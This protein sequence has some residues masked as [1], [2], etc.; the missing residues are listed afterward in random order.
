VLKKI[1]RMV[2]TG[3]KLAEFYEENNEFENAYQE[4]SKINNYRKAG[5]M[6]ERMEKW[7][8]AANLYI[9]H[10][11]IDRARKSIDQCFRTGDSW[12]TFEPDNGKTVSIETWLKQK[13]QVQRFVRYIKFVETLNNKGI[14]LVVILANKLRQALEFKSAADL[15]RTG[16]HLVN[17]NKETRLIINEVWLKYATECLANAKLYSDAAECMKELTITEVNIG[18]AIAMSGQN[19][20]RDYTPNLKTARELN[21]LPQLIQTLGDFDPF[22]LSYDLLKIQEPELSMELFF[23]FYGRILDKQVSNRER[24]ARNKKIQY[25]LNQYVIYYS[26]KGEYKR[27]AEIALLNSQKEIA[28]DLFKKAEM[29]EERTKAGIKRQSKPV[30]EDSKFTGIS[31]IP[32]EK[33]FSEGEMAKCPHCGE[34]VDPDWEVCP[35]CHNVLELRMCVCG[36]KIKSHWKRCPACQRTIEHPGKSTLSESPRTNE[37]TRPFKIFG[38]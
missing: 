37:D 2:L 23:E 29:E 38:D 7:H 6:L 16:F 34:V 19:P 22:N 9:K 17:R 24:E 14:P 28:A 25:C 12:E 27:A 11:D 3:A 10:D 30:S 33:I 26:E 18:D 8:D 36:Q 20:Y 21:F 4:Y 13:R 32:V 15:Y 31:E 5:E 35:G 1:K